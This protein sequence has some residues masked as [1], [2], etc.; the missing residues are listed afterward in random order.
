MSSLL[1]ASLRQKF[2]PSFYI[3]GRHLYAKD[4][5]K[6]VL[7][8]VNRMA[9]WVEPTGEFS[10][11]QIEKTGANAVRIMWM[12]AKPAAEFEAIIKNT[13]KL[14]MIPIIE[15]HDATGNWSKLPAVVD[16]WIDP[17]TVEVIKRH[18]DYLLVNIAN[19]AGNYQI[20]DDQ[21]KQG[22]K[23]AV[24]RMRAAGIHVPLIIDASGWGRNI[25]QL[26]NTGLWL[27][28]Q[29]PDHNLMFS[30]HWWHSDNDQERITQALEQSV[31]LNLPL[32]VGEFAHKEVGCKGTIAYQHLIKEC[33]R[34]AIGWLAWSWGGKPGNADCHEMDMTP[35][36]LFAD[37]QNWGK[38]VAVTDENSI[39]NT[40]VR[41]QFI[42]QASNS[43][44]AKPKMLFSR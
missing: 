34:L 25:E 43:L 17:A 9:V 32:M 10:L 36:G 19:E 16:Y 29:D 35:S 20:S 11:P 40:S 30:V 7:R 24:S 14:G 12:L 33:Q 2:A 31:E 37:L 21:F 3:Q 41:P 8:G 44:K 22:Y 23:S 27:Q 1:I 4:G 26:L 13:V 15:I 5:E 6:V 18:Q 39:K 42:R 38:E 28:E